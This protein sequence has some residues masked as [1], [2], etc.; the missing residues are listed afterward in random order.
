[1]SYC[2]N[3][4]RCEIC[5]APRQTCPDCYEPDHEGKCS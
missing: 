1:M 5:D 3:D 4:G 2:R